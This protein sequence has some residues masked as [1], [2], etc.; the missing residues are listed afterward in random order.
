MNSVD[1]SEHYE[2]RA[3]GQSALSIPNIGRYANRVNVTR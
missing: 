2:L 3:T 1:A